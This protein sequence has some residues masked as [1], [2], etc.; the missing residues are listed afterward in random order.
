MRVRLEKLQKRKLHWSKQKKNSQSNHCCKVSCGFDYRVL[1]CTDLVKISSNRLQ[2]GLSQRTYYY[3]Y[4]QEVEKM[5]PGNKERCQST[6]VEQKDLL[7]WS[8]WT[9]KGWGG[10]LKVLAKLTRLMII[11]NRILLWHIRQSNCKPKRSA[12]WMSTTLSLQN[13]ITQNEGAWPSQMR[14]SP[15]KFVWSADIIFFLH[16]LQCF[17]VCFFKYP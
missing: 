15:F 17:F 6:L 13:L 4:R 12:Q 9:S 14:F 11:S 2:L 16:Y 3:G 10:P 5:N 8:Q 1:K 7:R